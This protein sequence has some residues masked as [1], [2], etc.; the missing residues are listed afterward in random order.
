[1]HIIWPA[2]IPDSRGNKLKEYEVME[3]TN[4]ETPEKW[5]YLCGPQE[6]ANQ[7]LML[8]EGKCEGIDVPQDRAAAWTHALHFPSHFH[9]ENWELANLLKEILSLTAK[10]SLD[11]AVAVDW[12]KVPPTRESP[13]WS[14]TE[15]GDLVYRGKYY[16]SGADRETAR[17]ALV[18]AYVQLLDYM[19]IGRASCRERV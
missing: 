6:A 11:C 19:E 7:F 3:R 2:F 4:R 12:Y 15:I 10:Y 18:S 8:N 17:R 14:N 5:L 13:E 1:M 9:A 16:H